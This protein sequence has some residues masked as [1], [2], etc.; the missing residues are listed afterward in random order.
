MCDCSN[1]I[2]HFLLCSLGSCSAH[3]DFHLKEGTV[4]LVLQTCCLFA[5][6]LFLFPSWDYCYCCFDFPCYGC[7]SYLNR[8]AVTSSKRCCLYPKCSVHHWLIDWGISV[9]SFWLFGKTTIKD[10]GFIVVADQCL[11]CVTFCWDFKLYIQRNML[12]TCKFIQEWN[13]LCRYDTFCFNSSSVPES[14]LW[15]LDWHT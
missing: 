7:Y 6:L 10:R 14:V 3:F 8:H 9:L 5:A 2:F 15:G 4:L 11:F 1:V 12:H 13:S